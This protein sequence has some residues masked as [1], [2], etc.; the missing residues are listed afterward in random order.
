MGHIGHGS[1]DNV[2]SKFQVM[3]SQSRLTFPGKREKEQIF[4]LQT[5]VSVSPCGGLIPKKLGILLC[6]SSLRSY[7]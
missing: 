5:L 3:L 7:G 1:K 4:A 6:K 2:V